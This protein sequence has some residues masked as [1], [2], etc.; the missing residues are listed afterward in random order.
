M[1]DI[2]KLKA[3]KRQLEERI[4]R[5]E[6]LEKTKKRKE[7]TRRKIIIGGA[8]MAEATENAKARKYLFEI[9]EK[10]VIK[11]TDRVLLELPAAMDSAAPADQP[12]AANFVIRKD[13]EQI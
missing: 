10:R 2:E 1:S 11:P 5:V 8:V 7:D 13:S 3:K 9:L 12:S 4:K 6:A